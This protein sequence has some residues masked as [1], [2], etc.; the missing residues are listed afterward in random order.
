MSE[1]NEN[2]APAELRCRTIGVIGVDEDTDIVVQH[3]Y[4]AEGVVCC[5]N[6]GST[7][8]PGMAGLI[9]A[10]DGEHLVRLLLSDDEAATLAERLGRVVSLIRESQEAPADVEREMARLT[11]ARAQ[12]GES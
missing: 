4:H 5:G 1:T 8:D 2:E 6:C 11:A 10:Q 7:H 12:A 9:V 3:V